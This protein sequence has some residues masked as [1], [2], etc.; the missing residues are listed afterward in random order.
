MAD[1]QIVQRIES[2]N[3]G[4]IPARLTMKYDAMRA[5]PFVFFRGTAHLFWDD[6]A[7]DAGELADAPLTWACGDLHLENFGSFRGDNRLVYFD[8]N[9]FD[10]AALAPAT[11]DV[12]RMLA[13]TILGARA[14]G[15]H[16]VHA[17]T[18]IKTYLDAHRSA[19]VDGKA[20][21]VERTTATGMV[22]D[23]LRQAR[24]R[25]RKDVLDARTT[26]VHG[27]RR[28]FTD[29]RR[30]VPVSLDERA[31]VVDCVNEFARSRE[32]KGDRE[33]FHVLDVAARIAGTGS[34]GLRRY[35]VLAQ[36]RGGAHGQL[37]LDVKQVCASSLATRLPI[38]QP[39]WET[40]GARVVE[41]QRRMQ[42]ISPA[43]LSRVC[44]DGVD[45]VLRELQPTQDRIA[46]EASDGKTSRLEK[47]LATMGRL[48]AWSQL[49][50]ASRE[51]AATIDQLIAFGRARTWRHKAIEYAHH[52]ATVAA[53]D[54]R[55]FT[56]A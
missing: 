17:D 10:E 48:T 31:R 52:Y 30:A 47:V 44:I 28:L 29:G 15:F 46:L 11:A 14:L 25:R 21:W 32:R 41:I 50:S 9:D 26:I 40:P 19:L 38:T 18:L 13:S 16:E 53:R 34:L 7:R 20:R 39:Q 49:R 56:R 3:A 51:G 42:A 23:L 37:L 55:E 22:R 35:A 4:R 24:R 33:R 36:G 54:W 6:W 5:D 27:T 8:L 1:R 2:Y 43:L 12:V 45:F